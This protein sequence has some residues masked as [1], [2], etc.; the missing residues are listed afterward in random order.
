VRIEVTKDGKP[1]IWNLE[2]GSSTQLS[3]AKYPVTRTTLKFG[4]RIIAAGS[5]ARS[6]G[7]PH[8]HLLD[9]AAGGRLGVAGSRRVI[10]SFGV[11]LPGLRRRLLRPAVWRVAQGRAGAAAAPQLESGRAGAIKDLTGY[12]V[13]SSRALASAHDG[14]RRRATVTMLPVNSEARRI[15]EH[16]DPGEG[17]RPAAKPADRTARRAKSC[18][19][20]GRLAHQRVSDDN[21]LK[22]DTD[23]GHR[24]TAPAAASG[25][26]RRPTG[27]AAKLAGL[28]RPATVAAP[29]ADGARQEGAGDLRV[30]DRSR[31]RTGSAER[32]GVPYSENAAVEEFF[33]AFTEPNGDTLAGDRHHRHRP[34]LPHAAV[35]EQRGVQEGARRHRSGIRR[36][37]ARISPD[38]GTT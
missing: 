27:Q 20:P 5:R 18:A 30:V 12:W 16:V 14:A 7:A 10:E 25:G 28:I 6:G 36:L 15:T 2:W 32:T 8:P 22:I 9:Q 1:E 31:R 33:D 35:R 13:S 26:A 21:T 37:A 19:Y 23:A 17:T 24:Q 38:N 29:A 4:D 11:G 3:A 34:H